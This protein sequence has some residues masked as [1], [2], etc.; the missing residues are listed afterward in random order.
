MYIGHLLLNANVFMA[1]KKG[2]TGYG[3]DS[4]LKVT[5]IMGSLPE[6][7]LKEHFHLNVNLWFKC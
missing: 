4:R 1:R 2:Q 6:S 5:A 3:N 7:K